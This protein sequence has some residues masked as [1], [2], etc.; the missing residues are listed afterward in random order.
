M[1]AKFVYT[2]LTMVFGGGT[3]SDVTEGMNTVLNAL[4]E[5]L[6]QNSVHAIL[7]IFLGVAASLMTVFLFMDIVSNVQK[8]MITLE[9]LILIFIKYF[10]AMVVLIYLED[11][12]I[13]LFKFGTG[14]YNV[15]SNASQSGGALNTTS[16]GALKFFPSER[17]DGL[18]EILGYKRCIHRYMEKFIKGFDAKHQHLFYIDHSIPCKLDS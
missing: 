8:D 14:V 12:V 16:T 1:I 7:N 18:A 17:K 10:T 6:S 4:S 2:A 13:Y 15:L 9:R 11:I 3:I 5:A